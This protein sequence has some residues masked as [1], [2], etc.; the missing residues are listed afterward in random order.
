MDVTIVKADGTNGVR[1]TIE[2]SSRFE[3]LLVSGSDTAEK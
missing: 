2:A 3:T 1:Y